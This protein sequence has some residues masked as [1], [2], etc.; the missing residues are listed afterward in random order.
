LAR[1]HAKEKPKQLMASRR[2]I[3][4]LPFKSHP[5]KLLF[6][7]HLSSELKAHWKRPLI[8]PGSLRETSPIL[9]FSF[10]VAFSLNGLEPYQ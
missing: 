6:E 10:D 3:L 9:R 8:S 4:A 7:F 2:K 5:K 1:D